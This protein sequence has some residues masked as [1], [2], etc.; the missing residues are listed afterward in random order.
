MADLPAVEIAFRLVVAGALIVAP[1]LLFLGFWRFLSWLRDDALVERL[2]D[3]G[4]FEEARRPSA[5]DVL[6]T[7]TV[8]ESGVRRCPACDA[9][10]LPTADRCRECGNVL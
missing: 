10:N 3:R 4:V 9:R 7:A 6:A 5:A 1:T 8:S 2:A